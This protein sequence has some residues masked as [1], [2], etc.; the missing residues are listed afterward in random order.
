MYVVARHHAFPAAPLLTVVGAN[1][2]GEVDVEVTAGLA[3]ADAGAEQ[4]L[5]RAEGSPRDDRRAT[6]ADRVR[7]AVSVELL[8]SSEHAADP[9]SATVLDDDASRLDPRSQHSSR[10]NRAGHVYDVHAPV[11]PDTA[12][13]R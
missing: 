5:R 9:G 10:G 12:A 4:Q 2:A 13:V 8:T 6:G 1:P 11:G 3:A 7:A